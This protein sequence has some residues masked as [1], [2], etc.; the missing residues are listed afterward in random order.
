MGF[1]KLV[2]MEEY[3]GSTNIDRNSTCIFVLT[4]AHNHVVSSARSSRKMPAWGITYCVF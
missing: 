3:A 2:L 1:E 4:Y